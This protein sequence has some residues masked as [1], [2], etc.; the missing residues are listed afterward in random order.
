MSPIMVL[1]VISVLFCALI[2][3]ACLIAAINAD[4]RRKA[5]IMR[6]IDAFEMGI[7]YPRFLNTPECPICGG[8]LCELFDDDRGYNMWCNRCGMT[9]DFVQFNSDVEE[10]VKV[11]ARKVI[12]E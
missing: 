1:G 5:I 12:N 8:E 6:R 4:K 3:V 7:G 11:A 2:A 10:S 9:T